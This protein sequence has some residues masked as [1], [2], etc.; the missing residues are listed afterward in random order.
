MAKRIKRPPVKL[1]KRQEWLR[2]YELDESPPKIAEA[3]GYDVRTVRKQIL[4]AQEEREGK[5]ARVAVLREAMERHHRMMCDFAGKLDAEVQGEA[6][7]PKTLQDDRMWKA[8]KQHMPRSSLWYYLDRWDS[9]Q[10][11]LAELKQ[12]IKKRLEKEVGADPELKTQQVLPHRSALGGLVAALEFQMEQRCRGR[13]G[14]TLQDYFRTR[15]EGSGLIAIEY[16]AFNMGTGSRVDGNSVRKM[17]TN[18]EMKVT[19]WEEY[20][21]LGSLWQ[22]L[23]N[24]RD[25]LR[26]ELA[27]I[28]L[29]GV[30]TGHCIY[31][32]M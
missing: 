31:C 28:I 14:L 22:K 20:K 24:T 30:V 17:I 27:V 1:E 12:G 7:I 19:L 29:R 5:E 25:K 18:W 3:D 10:Q 4:L 21:E 11:Q 16:G 26:E 8:L 15:D 6:P 23:K 2:R 13:K 9:L 32:P